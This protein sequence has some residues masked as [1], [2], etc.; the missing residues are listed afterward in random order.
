VQAV[1]SEW[2]RRLAQLFRTVGP[3]RFVL[4]THLPIRLPESALAELELAS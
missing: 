1:T 2:V 3:N 4:G